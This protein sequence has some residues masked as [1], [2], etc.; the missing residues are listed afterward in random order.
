MLA[1]FGTLKELVLPDASAIEAAVGE[2]FAN[3]GVEVVEISGALVTL[4]VRAGT[5]C[6]G[7]RI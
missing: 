4:S 1:V 2:L 3:L 6:P 7:R 5:P